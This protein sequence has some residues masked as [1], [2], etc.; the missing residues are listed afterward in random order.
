MPVFTLSSI[1]K[2]FQA[3]YRS[4]YITKEWNRRGSRTK[5]IED[6]KL[7][8]ARSKLKADEH[9]F[10]TPP[11]WK[12]R[13]QSVTTSF[14]ETKMMTEGPA[15]V[16]PTANCSRT[17]LWMS[18]PESNPSRGVFLG[19]CLRTSMA[20]EFIFFHP[21]NLYQGNALLLLFSLSERVQFFVTPWTA[22]HQASLSFT[23]AHSLLKLISTELVMPSNRLI[24]MQ[25][26]SLPKAA[27]GCFSLLRIITRKGNLKTS[28]S[29]LQLCRQFSFLLLVSYSFITCLLVSFLKPAP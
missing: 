7:V 21:L 5:V 14:L 6:R 3:T 23:I 9:S 12:R 25:C 27:H 11:R 8:K 4:I 26:L 1:H 2:G 13:V 29:D 15:V 19:G 20:P 28:S 16:R 10:G 18:G 17:A 22:A 24:L